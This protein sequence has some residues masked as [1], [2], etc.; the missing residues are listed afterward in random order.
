MM[1]S[2]LVPAGMLRARLMS[3]RSESRHVLLSMPMCTPPGWHVAMMAPR[4]SERVLLPVCP[5]RAALTVVPWSPWVVPPNWLVQLSGGAV[6]SVLSLVH[7]LFLQAC[8][9]LGRLVFTVVCVVLRVLLLLC[10]AL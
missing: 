10:R 2:G 4:I 9:W 3:C 8:V 5:S 1:E 7:G 6:V